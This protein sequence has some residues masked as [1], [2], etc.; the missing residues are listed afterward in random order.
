M[1]ALFRWLHFRCPHQDVDSLPPPR[2]LRFSSLVHPLHRRSLDSEM[3][4]QKHR[5]GW[6]RYWKGQELS[7]PSSRAT[8]TPEASIQRGKS[9]R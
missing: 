5:Q 6:L 9:T 1:L 8:E 4:V 2:S 3:L 7:M